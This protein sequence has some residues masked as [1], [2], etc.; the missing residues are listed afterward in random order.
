MSNYK[1]IVQKIIKYLTIFF[2]QLI[3][4]LPMHIEAY[5]FIKIHKPWTGMKKY[6]WSANILMAI[7]ILLGLYLFKDVFVFVKDAAIHPDVV[8]ANI[9]TFFT[10]FSFEKLEGALSGSKKYLVLIILEI[11]TFHFIQR[12]LELQMGRK[13][14]NSVKV[15]IEAEKRMIK[16]AFSA[17]IM[18]IITIAVFSVFIGLFGLESIFK[19]PLKYLI[20]FYFLGFT[21]IDN[22]HECFGLT[23]KESRKK[24]KEVTGVAVAVGAV[25]FALMYVPIIGVVAAT[26]IGAVTATMAMQKYAPM[27]VV[28]E[29]EKDEE[30]FV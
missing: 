21:I 12:T 25:A 11:F 13:P 7:A 26:M 14:E 8:G 19:E 2:S 10:D 9:N 20:Q 29:E 23:L 15:F 18:E 1:N 3:G 28:E 27:E 5:K 22:Y 17:Y 24:T 30:G 4:T 16:A 6:G